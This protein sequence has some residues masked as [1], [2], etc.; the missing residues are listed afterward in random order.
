MKMT[1]I[2]VVLALAAC[3]LGA[4]AWATPK[5]PQAFGTKI[6]PKAPTTSILDIEKNPQKYAG[7]TV[8]VKGHIIEQCPKASTGHGCFI[9]LKGHQKAASALY[10]ELMNGGV[11]IPAVEDYAH[12]FVLG[13]VLVN[14]PDQAVSK[15]GAAG[16]FIK[17][18]QV[19]LKAKGVLIGDD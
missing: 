7:K 15:T 2:F 5:A 19:Y 1:R 11:M 16:G 9:M 6:N 4:F 8:L 17:D 10:I 13:E 12:A 18:G 14:T 3:C